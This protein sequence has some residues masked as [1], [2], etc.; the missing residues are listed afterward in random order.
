MCV[1][2]KAHGNGGK[3]GRRGPALV[4]RLP[5][6]TQCA[7]STAIEI[8]HFCPGTDKIVDEFFFRIIRGI[9]LGDGAQFRVGTK[10]Q[11]HRRCRVT[12]AC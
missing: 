12:V 5:W 2:G 7:G 11:I 9:H 8:H 3:K 10:H 6:A 1:P 4:R